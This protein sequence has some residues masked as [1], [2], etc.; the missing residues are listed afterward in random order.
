MIV[1]AMNKHV[2]RMRFGITV[3]DCVVEKAYG[4]AI[5]SVGVDP[6]VKVVGRNER[7]AG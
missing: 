7:S 3:V 1:D 4:A 2:V 5:H 6:I